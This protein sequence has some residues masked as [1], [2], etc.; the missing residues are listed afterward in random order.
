MSTPGHAPT[1]SFLLPRR[2]CPYSWSGTIVAC[3]APEEVSV[4]TRKHAIRRGLPSSHVAVVKLK[5]VALCVDFRLFSMWRVTS[6]RFCAHFTPGLTRRLCQIVLIQHDLSRS[7]WIFECCRMNWRR[8]LQISQCMWS[9]WH[10][11]L[12]SDFVTHTSGH[13]GHH[14]HLF[15]KRQTLFLVELFLTVTGL[16]L[17]NKEHCTCVSARRS[18]QYTC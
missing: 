3:V 16:D 12:L 11:Q 5:F 15:D 4:P 17:V 13:Q 10:L 1:W 14:Q 9:N 6:S 2:A 7:A 18:L 8:F